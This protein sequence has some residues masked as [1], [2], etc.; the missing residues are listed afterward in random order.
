MRLRHRGEQHLRN[1]ITRR[2]E[3][4]VDHAVLAGTGASNQ[5]T[6]ILNYSGVNVLSLGSGSANNMTYAA[7]VSMIRDAKAANARSGNAGFITNAY[8]EFALSQT[9]KQTSGVEGNFAYDFS[10]RLVGRPLFDQRCHLRLIR[11]ATFQFRAQVDHAA[12][13]GGVVGIGRHARVAGIHF[14]AAP[15]T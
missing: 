15:D 13:G 12:R 14:I 8:G 5:P 1:I 2:Y 7:L 10:G 11:Q 9:P 3:L 6:G 4:T